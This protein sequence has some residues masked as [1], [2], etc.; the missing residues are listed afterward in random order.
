MI[1]ILANKQLHYDTYLYFI[2]SVNDDFKSKRL[3]KAIFKSCRKHISL[4]IYY[5]CHDD[6]LH[7][8]SNK[9]ILSP[10]QPILAT[11]IDRIKYYLGPLIEIL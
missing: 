4:E 2:V 11:N 7:F 6:Q 3:L 1:I 10:V 9:L 8:S 5:M